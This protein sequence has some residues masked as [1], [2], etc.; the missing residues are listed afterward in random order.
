MKPTIKL[1]SIGFGISTAIVFSVWKLLLDIGTINII[2]TT[3]IGMI[4]SLGLYRLIATFILYLIQ[5]STWIKCKFLGPYFLEGTWVGFYIGA[6]GNVRYIIER[7]EQEV[8]SLVIR[9]KSFDE[10]LNY[11]S[12]WNSSSVNIDILNGKLSYMYDLSPIKEIKNSTGICFFS[13]DRDSQYDKAIG[14]TGFSADIHMGVK[15]RAKEIKVSDKCNMKEIE[16]LDHAKKLYEENKG[17]F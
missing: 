8:D 11:H 6:S 5:K 17:N 3:I 12:T 1:S 15:I 2:I 13:L 14:L 4:I 10:K 16:A 7:F 9:G